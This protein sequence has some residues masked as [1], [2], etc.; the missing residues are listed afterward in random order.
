VAY[1]VNP[2]FEMEEPGNRPL[3][4][5]W[6]DPEDLAAF[7]QTVR[8]LRPQVDFLIVSAHW[9]FGAG[10]ELAEYQRPLGHALI[11]AGADVIFGNHVH[12]VH[13]V[14]VYRGKAILYSP[15]NFIAQQP[16]EGLSEF[17]VRLLDEMSTDGYAAELQVGTSGGY[18]IRIIP[19]MTDANGLPVIVQGADFERIAERLVRL[20]DE[21]GTVVRVDGDALVV[22][23]L[24]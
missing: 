22:E 4:K 18:A 20:S 16:R 6:A 1:Q 13:G 9:G 23:G 3:V 21:L 11:E 12:A 14:E 24:A 7:V 5:T 8:D 10:E 15:G 19:T 2:Y 17:A